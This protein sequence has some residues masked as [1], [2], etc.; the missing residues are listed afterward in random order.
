[1]NTGTPNF[2]RE[3]TMNESM[4]TKKDVARWINRSTKTVERWVKKG[5]LPP[6][7]KLP[8]N[9]KDLFW[10]LE[11]LKNWTTADYTKKVDRLLRHGTV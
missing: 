11:A 9:D 4:M 3:T 2:I 1:M 8:G 5:S 7:F 10:T 6:P